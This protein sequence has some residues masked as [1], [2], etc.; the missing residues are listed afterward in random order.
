MLTSDVTPSTPFVFCCASPE[1]IW[2]PR[3]GQESTISIGVN[4]AT[5]DP[6]RAPFPFHYWGKRR[7]T[8]SFCRFQ[9]QFQE[10][11]RRCRESQCSQ[12]MLVGMTLKPRLPFHIHNSPCSTAR[13]KETKKRGVFCSSCLDEVPPHLRHTSSG[14]TQLAKSWHSR[15]NANPK[16]YIVPTTARAVTHAYWWGS[17]TLTLPIART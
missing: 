1:I 11:K 2:L 17:H 15:S 16:V 13:A 14:V 5:R 10:H 12:D 3:L 6:L 8:K 7:Q 4:Q 9:Q